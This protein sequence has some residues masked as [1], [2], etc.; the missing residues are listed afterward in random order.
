MGAGSAGAEWIVL[1]RP[2]WAAAAVLAAAP[3]VL[4]VLSR[5]RGRALPPAAVAA[6]CVALL[7]A[8]L[9]LSAPTAALSRSARAP[10]L[11]LTDVSGSMREQ[12]PRP[13]QLAFPPGT[14]VE[15][16]QFDA[17][18]RRA[19]PGQPGQE[20]SS[21]GEGQTRAGPALRLIAA[22]GPEISA[23][24]ILTDGRFTDADWT[25]A[26]E[27]VAR[28]GVQVLIVPA[29]SIPADGRV[30]AIQAVR[31]AGA[32]VE[33]AV[34]VSAETPQKRSLTLTRADRAEPLAVR[35]LALLDETPVTLRFADVVPED[36][37]VEYV[38]R[39]DRGD[40]F[41]ENDSASALVLPSRSRAAAVGLDGR[42]AGL[43]GAL[44]WPVDHL[45]AGQVPVSPA[46]LARYAVVV[47]RDPTGRALSLRQRRAL[48]EYVSGGGG[49]VLIG[50]GPHATP[51]DENDPLNRVLPL[52]GNPFQRRPLDL[53]VLLDRSGSMARRTIPRPG[54]PAQVKFDQAA[55]AVVALKQH[56]T[57]RDALT[58]ITFA[59]Q[60]RVAYEGAGAALDFAAL[61]DVLR[62][63]R[64]AGSTK[65]LP[66]LKMAL[67][68][69]ARA[70]RRVMVLVV[71]DL[72]TRDR[73]FD[74]VRWSEA[75]RRAGAALGVVAVAEQA[76]AGPAEPEPPLRRLAALLKAPFVRR[77]RL[78]GLARIFAE[79][80]RR[81]RGSLL[82]RTT[83]RIASEAAPFDVRAGELP[84]VSAYL[85]TA[86]QEQSET[87]ARIEGEPVLARR[88]AGLGRSVAL[89]LPL[90]AGEN[91]AWSESPAAARLVS[92]AARW[93][94]RSPN[95]PRFD[96]VLTRN[97]GVLRVRVTADDG[98]GPLNNLDL[99]VEASDGT[100]PRTAP[101][102]QTAPGRY[103]ATLAC[104]PQRPVAVMVRDGAGS[105]VWRGAA[106]ATYPSEYRRLGPDP[107]ALARLAQIT[108]G[109]MV[110]AGQLGQALRASRRERMT[111]LWPWL[112]GA[113]LGVM[114]LEWA[115]TRVVRS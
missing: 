101:L 18:L 4:A 115:L 37:A 8:G 104:S 67:R 96:A 36:A 48:G 100:S 110:S 80:V 41:P 27:A 25:G 17:R 59:D 69:P 102:V 46:A 56:L 52:V 58:V 107:K 91:A 84:T 77:D 22:R 76:E 88:R 92:A 19:E 24:V 93:A 11:L 94:A 23:A 53:R 82:R 98:S 51:A 87:L 1:G 89:A 28:S 103:E 86:P 112:V 35:S 12:F 42:W 49:L 72:Q 10:V 6:Q 78:D 3:M 5:R 81:A 21:R 70:G 45:A 29:E 95:D 26:A 75:F 32:K 54:S 47:V 61:R 40:A 7:L 31:R 15:R 108:G 99:T 9:A 50:I 74:P 30:L 60:A 43:L 79:M 57:A 2:A 63:V 90:G 55:E 14:V 20:Q 68:R 73:R 65:V 16:F 105:V 13:D 114:L 106:A 109:Q 33:L 34:T 62:Q 64:P 38:A 85:L 44:P 71:S 111:E 39:L 83:A 66:A 113:A 97:G